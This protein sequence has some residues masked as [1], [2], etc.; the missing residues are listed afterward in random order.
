MTFFA[1][2]LPPTAQVLPLADDKARDSESGRVPLLK[3][4]VFLEVQRNRDDCQLEECVYQ[5]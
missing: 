4:C 2:L 1:S 3:Y 5:V